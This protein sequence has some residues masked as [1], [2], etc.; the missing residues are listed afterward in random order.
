M[1]HPHS[2]AWLL[3]LLPALLAPGCRGVESWTL[4]M[5]DLYQQAPALSTVQDEPSPV[6]VVFITARALDPKDRDTNHD[7]TP[8]SDQLENRALR[9]GVFSAQAQTDTEQGKPIFRYTQGSI[10]ERDTFT[11]ATAR[12]AQTQPIARP[13]QRLA[14]RIAGYMDQR[15][16]SDLLIY[17]HG[18]NVRM[19]Q[20]LR[21]GIQLQSVLP[22]TQVV[23]FAWPSK[24]GLLT[25]GHADA[26]AR[27]VA[28]RL[29]DLVEVAVS[30]AF[31]K[32]RP[33]TVW[34]LGHSTGARI[35]S[36]T[37]LGLPTQAA[38]SRQDTGD[39]TPPAQ[40]RIVLAAPDM[41][42][43]EFLE[44]FVRRELPPQID[45]VTVYF[46]GQD[47][48]LFFSDILR[49]GVGILGGN[50]EKQ[51]KPE[52]LEGVTGLAMIDAAAVRDELIGHSYI[53]RNPVVLTDLSLMIEH[54]WLLE[55]LPEDIEHAL[56]ARSM[57]RFDGRN[58]V[59]ILR[60]DYIKALDLTGLME[61]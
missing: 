3:L 27:T 36:D 41:S 15:G 13:A 43:P 29:R 2:H 58:Q 51:L 17:V 37:M 1:K 44:R 55:P 56:P 23:V 61:E 22:N 33:T 5:P 4:A 26:M 31:Q 46:S 10:D 32:E 8:Y 52:D 21:H 45:S 49:M 6:E 11:T 40:A 28:T 54:D 16:R 7:Q 14:D 38:R 39:A 59:Y 19:D 42:T 18:Y 50:I 24:S 48:A 57:R 25:Y 30:D 12:R 34:L 47:W 20:A 9:Y 35:I 53:V 60:R